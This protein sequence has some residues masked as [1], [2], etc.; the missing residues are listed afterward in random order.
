VLAALLIL[1]PAATADSNDAAY[2]NGLTAHG[3]TASRLG[4]A[5]GPTVA[6]QLGHAICIDLGTVWTPVAEGVKVHEMSVTRSL[7]PALLVDWRYGHGCAADA[8]P[9][10]A[11][12]AVE[13]GDILVTSCAVAFGGAQSRTTYTHSRGS[14]QESQSSNKLTKGQVRRPG[15][16]QAPGGLGT[17]GCELRFCLRSYIRP[18]QFPGAKYVHLRLLRFPL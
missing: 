2:F 5:F 12:C 9:R 7:R 3:I 18:A 10:A 8:L 17:Q 1:A 6:I 15:G 4:P 13:S 11:I 16:I 14:Q